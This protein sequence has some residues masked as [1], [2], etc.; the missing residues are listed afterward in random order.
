MA[1]RHHSPTD[2]VA[3]ANAHVAV[4]RVQELGSPEEDV[5]GVASFILLPLFGPELRVRPEEVEQGRVVHGPLLS[6]NLDAQ[7][8]SLDGLPVDLAVG[9]TKH[10]LLAVEVGSV[11]SLLDDRLAAL[12]MLLHSR[13][14]KRQGRVGVQVDFRT[15]DGRRLTLVLHGEFPELLLEDVATRTVEPADHLGADRVLLEGSGDGAVESHQESHELTDLFPI[16]CFL[17]FA[18]CR[19]S[20]SPLLVHLN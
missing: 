15:E 18:H 9:A 7:F 13:T 19:L 12:D 5:D 6:F 20:A 3:V 16:Q 1:A 2:P 8:F 14:V 4:R 11:G 17:V 10:E